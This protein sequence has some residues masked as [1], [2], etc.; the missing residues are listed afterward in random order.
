M[1]CT[2]TLREMDGQRRISCDPVLMSDEG[3]AR[4]LKKSFSNDGRTQSGGSG[5]AEGDTSL[6]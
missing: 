1:Y 6:P 3:K 2:V 4:G 5:E